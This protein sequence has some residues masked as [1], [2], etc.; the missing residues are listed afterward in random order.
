MAAKDD[1][2]SEVEA[3][4]NHKHNSD[5]KELRKAHRRLS[6]NTSHHLILFL[7]TLLVAISAIL[8]TL[9]YNYQET[10]NV[11]ID[12]IRNDIVNAETHIINELNV[13]AKIYNQD[14]DKTIKNTETLM[15]AKALYHLKRGLALGKIS[16]ID[17]DILEKATH[18]L[19]NDN[20]IALTS[21]LKENSSKIKSD[22]F[23]VD[24]INSKIYH[25]S[26]I[27][28]NNKEENQEN[29]NKSFTTKLQD[30]IKTKT[31]GL[32]KVTDARKNP[33]HNKEAHQ[34]ELLTVYIQAKEYG[35]A[36]AIIET[37]DIAKEAAGAELY[38]WLWV[39]YTISD[40]IDF[41]LDDILQ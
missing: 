16:S 4:T 40:H 11:G 29:E 19:T 27:L 32:I 22:K 25:T 38:D 24:Y 35:K 9:L 30:F 41:L 36:A 10:W 33:E 26:S 21:F 12:D 15:T 23:L 31:S 2:S 34:L 14:M 18:N 7:L 28:P 37:T 20:I 5:V 6:D 1:H 39:K 8:C 3:K 17:M 13:R